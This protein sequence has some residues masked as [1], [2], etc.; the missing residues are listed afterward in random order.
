MAAVLY[1][2]TDDRVLK[3]L[4]PFFKER[5]ESAGESHSISKVEKEDKIAEMLVAVKFD[6]YFVEEHML[7]GKPAKD[8]LGSFLK[9]FPQIKGP[10]VL[11]GSE[12]SPLKIY[13]M[14]EAGWTDYVV[15][16][17]DKP[18][19]IEKFGLYASGKRS[20]DIRQV[21]S[22]DVYQH[23]DIAKP[24]TISKLSEFDCKVKSR[25][26]ALVNDLV[27]LYS[28]IFGE[29]TTKVAVLGRCYS[30]EPDQA[31]KEE[32]LNSY[33]FVGI[34]TDV[35]AHIRTNLRKAYVSKKGGS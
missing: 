9:R 3:I 35:L 27:T 12:S 15:E 28:S 23:T 4:E 25:Q 6:M 33:Y 20:A 16:P 5:L 29:G 24:G 2:G 22:M 17:P 31:N 11:V 13:Q 10:I 1:Y 8:W 32:F 18:L 19:L 30:S 14:L 21:Y 34:T 26:P 7:A